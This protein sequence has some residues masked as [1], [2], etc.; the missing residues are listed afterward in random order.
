MVQNTVKKSEG[1]V[2]HYRNGWQ[3]VVPIGSI[4]HK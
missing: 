3:P 1:I 2:G 4:M